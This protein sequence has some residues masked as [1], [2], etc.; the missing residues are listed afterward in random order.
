MPKQMK[1]KKE[2]SEF[3]PLNAK[4]ESK[5]ARLPKGVPTLGLRWYEI[6]DYTESF[7]R[8]RSQI[9]SGNFRATR[10]GWW[11]AAK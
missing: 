10:I 2:R 9:L 4:D 8:F 3:E 7:Q 6:D 5:L 1:A 11:A